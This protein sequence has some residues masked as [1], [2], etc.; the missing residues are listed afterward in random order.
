MTNQTPRPA[1]YGVRKQLTADDLTAVHVQ[2]IQLVG[3]T[4]VEGVIAE[5]ELDGWRERIDRLIEA[6]GA[7]YGSAEE[8]K[9]LGEGNTARAAM[10]Q[11]R[12]FVELVKI[13]AVLA[14]CRRLLGPYFVVNQ[15]N[16]VVNPPSGVRHHQS[17]WHRDLPYQHYTSSAPLAVSALVCI[18]PFSEVT[19]GTVVLPASHKLD[20]FPSDQVVL[21]Q[22]RTVTA[23]AGSCLVFDAMLYHRTGTNRSEGLRRAVNQMF[24]IPM[25]QQQIA[26]PAALGPDFPADPAEA[27]LLGY[28]NA[29]PSSV[30]DWA[31]SRQKR[32][33]AAKG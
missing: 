19:G 1:S 23:P 5:G 29:P 22:E 14:I 16:V 10:A 11:D 32:A 7:F 17:Q 20:E 28:V 8:A 18:D 12:A 33:A 31:A 9:A 21:R 2:E 30:Q 15:Q 27:Q 24:T 4:V 6:Q 25:F 13:E 3:Y 26:L